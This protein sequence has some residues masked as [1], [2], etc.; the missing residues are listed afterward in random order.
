[1]TLT[2]RLLTA[3]DLADLPEVLPSGSV[4]YELEAGKLRI[5][6]PTGDLHGGVE[7][8]IAGVLLIHGQWEGHGQ[9][10]SGEVGIILAHDP[11]TVLGA[12]AVFLTRDQLPARR[13]PE[14]YLETV[15]AL[16]VEVVSKNDRPRKVASKVK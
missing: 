2:E 4:R 14:G 8:V 6:A 1:M 16:V 10:R 5:M 3:A 13:S 9:V 15:P 12:D 11:D 7:A